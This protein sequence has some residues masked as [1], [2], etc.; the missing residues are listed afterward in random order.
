[1]SDEH[2]IT[3]E[4]IIEPEAIEE[5]EKME[6]EE[7][8]IPEG[9]YEAV[10]TY[11]ELVE[12]STKSELS[13]YQGIPVYSVRI[14]FFDCPEIGK[15]KSSFFK[16]TPFKLVNDSGRPKTAYTSLVGLTKAMGTAGSPVAETFE[17]AKVTRFKVRVGAFNT[18]DGRTINFLK[19]ISQAS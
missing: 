13:P 7:R 19:S 5:Q 9:T 4:L 15:S 18:D 14:K 8:L 17:Q 2:A 3:M 1:M 10:V 12:E 16:L 11:Y 6:R